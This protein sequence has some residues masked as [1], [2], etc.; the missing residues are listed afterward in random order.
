MK[1]KFLF[2][3]LIIIITIC[4]IFSCKSM[5]DYYIQTNTYENSYH[6]DNNKS[7][8]METFNKSDDSSLIFYWAKWCGVCQRIKPVWENS[9]EVI[10]KKYP[11]LKIEEIECDN[12]EKCFIYL[13]NKKKIIEGVP[14]II[15]RKGT[16][17]IEYIRDESNNILC[18]KEGDD[19]IRFLDLYLEK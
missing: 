11:N 2:I 8:I 13:N 7:S 14:T 6:N 3:F 1:I 18:N 19:L 15:L 4:I 9:K 16:N 5:G 17:D 10:G 12:P